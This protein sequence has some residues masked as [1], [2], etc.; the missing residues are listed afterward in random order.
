METTSVQF[1]GDARTYHIITECSESDACPGCGAGYMAGFI[2]CE[3][4]K[5]PVKPA[6]K[7]VGPPNESFCM[8]DV[9]RKTP[10]TSAKA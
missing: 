1:A 7:P 5:T 8:F 3:Y 10:S 4:C 9:R 2:E 6:C